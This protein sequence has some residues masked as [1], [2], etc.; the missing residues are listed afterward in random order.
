MKRGLKCPFSPPRTQPREREG[1]FPDEEGTEMY[2]AAMLSEEQITVK[3]P[4]PMKRGLKWA[5]RFHISNNQ[6]DVKEPSPMK[7]GLK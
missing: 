3:E 5:L 1:T 4:S 6:R 2:N 7:R